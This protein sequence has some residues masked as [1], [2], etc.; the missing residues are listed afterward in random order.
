MQLALYAASFVQVAATSS[1]RRQNKVF[2]TL[3]QRCSVETYGPGAIP[4]ALRRGEPGRGTEEHR[5]VVTGGHNTRKKSGN[6][7]MCV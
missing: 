1:Y 3:A 4:G 5:H 2:T 6:S 7:K